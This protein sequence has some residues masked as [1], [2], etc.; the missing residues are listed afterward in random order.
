VDSIPAYTAG[1]AW[2]FNVHQAL[3]GLFPADDE[4]P[5]E[6]LLEASAASLVAAKLAGGHGMGYADDVLCG[7]IVCCKRAL[8]AADEALAGL[9]ALRARQLGDAA[10]LDAVLAEGRQVRQLVDAWI[11]ELRSRVWWA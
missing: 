6:D 11:S 2:S 5:D 4:E 1:C 7:N 3:V 8:A 10:R 9:A